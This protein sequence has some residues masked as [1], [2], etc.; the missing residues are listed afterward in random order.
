MYKSKLLNTQNLHNANL[1][2]IMATLYVKSQE[3]V[4]HCYRLA[5]L[6][7]IIGT[8][9]GLPSQSLDELELVA[10]LHDIGKIGIDDYILNKPGKLTSEEWCIMKKHPEIGYRIAMSTPEF[11]PIADYILCHHEH[12]NGNGY[13]RGLKGE[14]IPHLVRILAVA[15]AYDAMTTDRVYRKAMTREAAIAEIKR[16][17]GTQFDPDI[18]EKYNFYIFSRLTSL[19]HIQGRNQL[20]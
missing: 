20:P 14:D 15:D 1:K 5:S 8:K 10:M 6:S 16:N 13:P 17:A 19:Q 9:L 4:E 11:Q 3:T 18:V 7:R 12:W 2:S